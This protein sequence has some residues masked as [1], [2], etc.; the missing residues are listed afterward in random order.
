MLEI[1]TKAPGTVDLDTTFKEAAVIV[2]KI[3]QLAAKSFIGKQQKLIPILISI[4]SRHL[5]GNGWEY[6]SGNGK[7]YGFSK[8]ISKNE[9]NNFSASYF[10]R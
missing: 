3:G 10:G 1:N 2:Q 5:A 8:N 9:R 7:C 6:K 4:L